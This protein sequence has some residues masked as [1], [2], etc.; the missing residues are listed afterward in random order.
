MNLAGI[1]EIGHL[2]GVTKQ[3][4]SQIVVKESF[5]ARLDDPP[6]AMGPVWKRATVER[7]AEKNR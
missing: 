7:W 4:A 1:T 3:R 5:P 2:L 6:L